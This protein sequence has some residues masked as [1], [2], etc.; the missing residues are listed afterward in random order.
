ME[1]QKLSLNE[2]IQKLISNYQELKEKYLTLIHE[3][4]ELEKTKDTL[5]Q[6]LYEKNL[7]IEELE[8]LKSQ[9]EKLTTKLN[10]YEQETEQA[11][12]KI[13]DVLNQVLEL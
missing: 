5:N 10:M 3:K 6:T 7:K 4:E 1:N 8:D 11:V 12:T 13:D 2:K 9:V